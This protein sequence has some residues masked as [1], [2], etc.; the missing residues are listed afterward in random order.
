[1]GHDT[2]QTEDMKTQVELLQ[3]QNSRLRIESESLLK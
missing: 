2:V 3:N 1:M